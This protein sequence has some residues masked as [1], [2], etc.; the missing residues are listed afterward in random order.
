MI[1]LRRIFSLSFSLLK[2]DYYFSHAAFDSFQ[3]H[4]L[5]RFRQ[6]QAFH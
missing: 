3:L 6:R 1:S 2:Y 5:L 4:E